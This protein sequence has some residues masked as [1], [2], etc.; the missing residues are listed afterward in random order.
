MAGKLG[1]HE[2]MVLKTGGVPLFHYSEDG[3]RRLDELL[4]GF[5]SAIS[6]FATEFG[7]RSV[8]SL[9]FEGSELLYEQ[10]E[11]DCI[12]VFLSTTGAPKKVLRAVLKELGRKFIQKYSNK[13]VGGVFV[14]EDF[15]GFK[16]IV[17]T[18]LAYYERILATTSNLSPFVIPKINPKA[19]QAAKSEGFLDELHREFGNLG[20]NV[21]DS[22]NGEKPVYVIRDNLG[23]E[24][25]EI[26][27]VIEYLAIWG[28]LTVSK[29]CP[30]I[31]DDDSRFDAYLDIIGLPRKDYQ[32]LRRAKSLCNGERY[33]VE[34]SDKLGV[35][36]ERLYD[37]L[38]KLGNEVKWNLVQVV[39]ISHR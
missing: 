34:I 6:S 21:L 26:S 18:A 25:E 35:T 7:E 2:F 16:E 9:S 36:S 4:S 3:S 28:I 33:I 32:L 24:E 20:T 13:M 38:D 27:E 8:Q 10:V 22:I 1:I 5:L 14:E 23:I 19:M 29:M 17:E 31:K 30:Y 11:Q 12:F 15:L 37:V 39:D